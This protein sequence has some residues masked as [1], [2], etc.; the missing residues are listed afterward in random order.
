MTA[1]Q[2]AASST[3]NMKRGADALDERDAQSNGAGNPKDQ[4]AHRSKVQAVSD[5]D[6]DDLPVLQAGKKAS[7]V[8]KGHECPY[9]DTVSRQ[10]G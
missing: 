1:A 4:D 9:L 5:E 3:A 7:L 6:D 8:R 10:V 2:T